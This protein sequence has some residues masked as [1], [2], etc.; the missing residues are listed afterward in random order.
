M[1]KL[2]CRQS[3]AHHGDRMTAASLL[4]LAYSGSCSPAA[5]A[6]VLMLGHAAAV[7]DADR[8]GDHRHA[9]DQAA[10]DWSCADHWR[11]PASLVATVCLRKH[12]RG[13]VWKGDITLSRVIVFVELLP[14]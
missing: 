10:L 12:S 3:V 7:D 5:R 14:S 9:G 4:S 2:T 13:D 1:V 11:Q 8:T 6:S